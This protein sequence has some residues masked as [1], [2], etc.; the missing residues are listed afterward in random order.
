MSPGD[1]SS[2]SLSNAPA[3]RVRFDGDVPEPRDRYWRGIVLYR[4]D[5][6]GWS[7]SDPIP[8]PVVEHLSVTG[9]P[10]S[11]QVTLEPTNQQYV[12][13]LDMPYAWGLEKGQMSRQQTLYSTHPI[14]QR[15]A[16]TVD[17]YPAYTADAQLDS[18]ARNVYTSL[19]ELDR[20]PRTTALALEMRA[21]AASTGEFIDA[22]LSK[23][24]NEAFYYTLQPPSLGRNPIDE[25]LFETRQGFC[26]H[27]ASTFAVMMRAAGVPARVV[28]GY[29]GGEYNP[30]G[31]YLLV[32]QSD[33]HAWAEVWFPGAG[34]RRVD[35]TS[36]VAPERIELGF[37]DS[38]FDGFGAE[39]GLAMPSMFLHNLQ[40]YW[41]SL[42]AQ[43][44]EWV[45]GYGPDKQNDFMRKLGM[46][47]PSWRK[48]MLTLI[49]LVV[50]LILIV[51]T[52]LMLRYRPPPRDRAAM[53]YRRFIRKTGLEPEVGETPLAFADRV[54]G[55]SSLDP[56]RVHDITGA[57]LAARYAPGGPNA[58]QELAR[59]VAAIR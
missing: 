22:V 52:V 24:H 43:W 36:A 33:A 42:N 7:S 38:L 17:S 18:R 4:F 40:M 50:A 35:P 12:F 54:N 57:Y 3:F 55:N 21:A 45:L 34:W 39:W 23:F 46:D 11:Y 20:N 25:F 32:R 48:M 5:G 29:Q 2:L 26:E 59:Q 30:R 53:L 14:D 10:V 31:D 44:N 16:Y 19:P 1:I 56:D 15:M 8:R 49:S 58:L 41:D 27:Y 13:A 47:D 51:S 6:R 9:D 37:T 28:I